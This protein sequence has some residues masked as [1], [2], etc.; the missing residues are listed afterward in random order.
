MCPQT[1]ICRRSLTESNEIKNKDIPPILKK[2]YLQRGIKNT[3]ELEWKTKNLISHHQLLNI[4]KA[5]Y[6][7][8]NAIFKRKKIVVIGDFDV[9]G[10]CGTAISVLSLTRL[11][12]KNVEF[13]IPNRFKDGYGLSPRIVK[14]A[15][16]KKVKLLLQ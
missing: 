15:E 1:I 13:I 16:K 8:K 5:T 3:K 10:A 11:G 12:A 4:N 2:I 6:I 7:L 9:D 14:I